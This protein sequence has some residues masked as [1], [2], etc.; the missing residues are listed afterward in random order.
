VVS[1]LTNDLPSCTS[2]GHILQL[3][4]VSLERFYSI[5]EELRLQDIWTVRQ[6]E[7]S[8]LATKNL[9]IK[10][11]IR[12]QCSVSTLI[13]RHSKSKC[14]KQNCPGAPFVAYGLVWG[15]IRR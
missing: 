2:S 7:L 4:K 5:I 15:R 10:S 3:C 14:R 6:K 11:I 1:Q 8:I 9:F 12:V 13:L